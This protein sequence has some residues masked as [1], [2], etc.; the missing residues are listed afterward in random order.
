M[1]FL[2]CWWRLKKNRC[3]WVLTD[4]KQGNTDFKFREKTMHVHWNQF[5]MADSRMRHPQNIHFYSHRSPS[6]RWH[7]YIH[8]MAAN[9]INVCLGHISS[10][11]ISAFCFDVSPKTLFNT[12]NSVQF[13]PLWQKIIKREGIKLIM[14]LLP[15]G[16]KCNY[17]YS[18]LRKPNMISPL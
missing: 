10:M 8:H 18:H 2:V 14:F 7:W 3:G 1:S 4:L 13:L 11:D 6:E 5:G 9:P 16:D 15:Q 12:P 17:F